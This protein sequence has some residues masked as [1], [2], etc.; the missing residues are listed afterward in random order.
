M[1][2]KIPHFKIPFLT[3]T[4]V[5]VQIWTTQYWISIIWYLRK[6]I[7]LSAILLNIY[8]EYLGVFKSTRTMRFVYI[9]FLKIWCLF[10]VTEVTLKLETHL[11]G[12]LRHTMHITRVQMVLQGKVHCWP[13]YSWWKEDNPDSFTMSVL[14]SYL[15][16]QAGDKRFLLLF[17]LLL[18]VCKYT[19]V[20]IL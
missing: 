18:S 6:Y 2:S 15:S 8:N 3:V 13:N 10:T 4:E 20:Q 19:I 1:K 12:P 16:T 17:R 9:L 5:T 11:N 7:V 14:W